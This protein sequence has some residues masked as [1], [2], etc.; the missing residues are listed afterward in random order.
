MQ[1]EFDINDS[2]DQAA[3]NQYGLMALQM[4]SAIDENKRYG[5][6]IFNMMFPHQLRGGEI[7]PDEAAYGYELAKPKFHELESG[8]K[9]V[10]SEE[11]PAY[12]PPNMR[13]LLEYYGNAEIIKARICRVPLA[14]WIKVFGNLATV[15]GLERKRREL[16]AL[17]GKPYDDLFHLYVDLAVKQPSG[18]VA[19]FAIE[20]N[21][22]AEFKI[23]NGGVR[24]GAECLD[25]PPTKPVTL[26][27]M[28][29]RAEVAVGPKK[30]WIYS[31]NESTEGT[32]CQFF[33]KNIL[34]NG[35]DMLTPE[36]AAFASQNV[37]ELLPSWVLGIT[38]GATDL[39]NKLLSFLK[40]K[41]NI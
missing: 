20:K 31:L 14:R 16:K 2:Y 4:K 24:Q 1:K 17:Y 10:F 41:G 9:E 6:P 38:K 3:K 33:A 5:M 27:E 39:A 11:L 8:R 19:V 21:Q 37:G 12:A 26:S 28:F 35:N 15:G 13:H 40:G 25:Q 36:G 7:N 32:N 18:E 30:L 34:S 23:I 29:K 22:K